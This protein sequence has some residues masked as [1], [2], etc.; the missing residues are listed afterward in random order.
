VVA[1]APPASA[2][3]RRTIIAFLNIIQFLCWSR[4]CT[5]DNCDQHK[6][7]CSWTADFSVLRRLVYGCRD[8]KPE[9]ESRAGDRGYPCGNALGRRREQFTGPREIAARTGNRRQGQGIRFHTAN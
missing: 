1:T 9:A 8:P 6:M 2:P 4:G 3:A 7:V 5:G